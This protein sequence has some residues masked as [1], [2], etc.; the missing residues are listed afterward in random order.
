MQNDATPPQ[1][2]FALELRVGIAPTID[3]GAGPFGVRRTVAITGG[4]FSGPGI[5]GHVQP[6]GADWQF[7]ES[8]GL[9]S[10]EAQYVIET[11][12]GVLIEVRN[13]GLRRGAPHVLARLAAG[14][15]VPAREYY[16]RTTPRFNPPIGKYEWLRRSVFVGVG[17]RY[18]DLVVVRVWRVA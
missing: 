10:V 4:T 14:E 9:T 15:A 11:D 17:E 13:S 5:A 18:A 16:F 8:D 2:E 1:L 6:G 7:V 12:D 3:L